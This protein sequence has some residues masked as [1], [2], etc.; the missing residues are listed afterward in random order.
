MARFARAELDAQLAVF[1]EADV[2][3]AADLWFGPGAAGW[4][5]AA[6]RRRLDYDLAEIDA[7][8]SDLVNAILRHPR[9]QAL[10]AVWR[11]A[12]WLVSGLGVDGATRLR[13]LDARWPEMVR[14]LER[15]AEF[16][17]SA[18]FEKIYNEEYGMP[19]GVPYSLLIGL[20]EVRHRPTRE[21]PTDDVTALRHLSAVAA[22]AFAPLAM[23]AAPALFG[24]DRFGELDLRQSLNATFRLGEYTR[25]QG[26]Q[27][28]PDSRFLGLVAPR[29]LLRG[30]RRGRAA[31]DCGFRY[32]PDARDHVWGSGALALAH[33]CLRAFNDYRWPAAVRGTVRDQIAGG[34]IV[35]LAPVDFE[36]DGPLTTLKF[37]VEVNMSEA[38]E[39][40]A[41]EAGLIC[42]RRLKDTPYLAVYNMPSLHRPRGAYTTEIAKINEQLGGMF[43][44]MLC[45]SRF[46]HYIKI[47]AREWIGSFKSAEECEARLQRWLNGFTSSGEQ[48]SF[49]EKARYP[50][51]EGRIRVAEVRGKPG[52][53]ECAVMLRPHF[54]LDQAI[55][56]FHL[57]TV[58]QG[59]AGL[60]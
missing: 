17:Q 9:L 49:E 20:Y 30:P 6:S 13:L 15:A 59:A 24:V 35:G 56:E 33:I 46:A 28:S 40:E 26:L 43:N 54:Q 5:E 45:V 7:A 41:S 25:L 34:V 31:D 19:G 51:Q 11:G 50:L 2:A 21:H 57:V 23:G 29:I 55:S 1:L 39:R 60:S 14:D 27:Q 52:A 36:T 3:D 58:V 48:L 38:L 10:E 32:E 8:I 22:A 16:D 18:L 42:I 44:Y 53:Y 37:Q 47:I 4:S 12:A